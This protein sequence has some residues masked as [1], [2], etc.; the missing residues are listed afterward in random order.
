MNDHKTA[1]EDFKWYYEK[2]YITA[3][4][5]NCMWKDKDVYWVTGSGTEKQN[6]KWADFAVLDLLGNVK[7]RTS[8]AD[9]PERQV[10][11]N[12]PSIE[13]GAHFAALSESGKAASVH[14]HSPNTVALAALFEYTDQRG[15][16]ESLLV[17]ILNNN[18]P[19]LFRYTKVGYIV[20]FLEPGSQDLHAHIAQSMRIGKIC[21]MQRH[22]VFAIGDT[23]KECMEHI[24]RLEHISTIL[25]KIV[26][27]SGKLES[28]I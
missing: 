21:I 25:L 15:F 6:L 13:T 18:W 1:T 19:E 3:R 23:L 20:P 28:I 16:D 11:N 12:K 27:A 2:G 26:T 4:D 8:P 7:V 5:G 24:V 14:V 22:G 9:T 17:K 10:F